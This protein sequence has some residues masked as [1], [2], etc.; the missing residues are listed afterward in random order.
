MKSTIQSILGGTV[1]ILMAGCASTFQDPGT[2][3]S[4]KLSLEA[5]SAAYD[6]AVVTGKG[7][8]NYNGQAHHFTMT[9]LGIGGTGL[10][11]VSGPGEVY[12]LNKL[13]D[14]AGTYKGV[15]KGLTLFKGRMQSKVTNEHGVVVYVAAE[16]KGIASDT[17]ARAF[18]V[19][20]TD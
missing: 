6:G 13:A 7:T 1:M 14:F 20:L 3:P 11:K 9:G 18:T 17:G 12:N 19:K 2:P 4:A 10:Q 5:V 16:T 15:S 8:L